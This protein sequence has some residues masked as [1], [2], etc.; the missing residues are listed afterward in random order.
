MF[1]FLRKTAL[2]IL[3]SPLATIVTGA[4][5][6]QAVLVANNDTFPVR[7][8]AVRVQMHKEDTVTLSDGTIM[9]DPLHCVMT[10]KTHLNFLADNFDVHDGIKSVGDILIDLG[11]WGWTF[12]PYV[13]GVALLGKIKE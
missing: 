12:A 2:W 7:I 3:L 6:N 11:D 13:W 9:L 8:S 10:N 1:K 5:L 4:G